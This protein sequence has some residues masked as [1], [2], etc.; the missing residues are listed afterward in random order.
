MTTLTKLG[1]WRT[2]AT[3]LSSRGHT[4]IRRV[5]AGAGKIVL[6]SENPHVTDACSHSPLVLNDGGMFYN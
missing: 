4:G 2:A 6:E 1:L 3:T 5:S